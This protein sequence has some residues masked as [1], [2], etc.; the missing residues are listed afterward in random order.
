MARIA[1]FDCEVEQE[2]KAGERLRGSRLGGPD[3]A[4][5]NWQGPLICWLEIRA[6]CAGK[7]SGE[8]QFG[9]LLAPLPPVELR[10]SEAARI[11]VT[12]S[13]RAWMRAAGPG[14]PQKGYAEVAIR[15]RAQVQCASGA[16]LDL[17]DQFAGR[18]A[19]GE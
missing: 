19:W 17:A 10:A 3:G 11:R 6:D 15:A 4:A 16:S 9:K 1:S 13:D 18:F 2:E 14:D 7:L 5:W 8:V 12:F